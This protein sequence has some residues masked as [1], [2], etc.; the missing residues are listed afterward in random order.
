MAPKSEAWK[1]GEAEQIHKLVEK[2]ESLM[3]QNTSMYLR[4]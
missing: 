2:S 3:K 1:I 4:A